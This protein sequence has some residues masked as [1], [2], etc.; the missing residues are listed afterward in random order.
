MAEASKEFYPAL[1]NYSVANTERIQGPSPATGYRIPASRGNVDDTARYI[2]RP[3]AEFYRP[4]LANPPNGSAFVWPVGVE[5]FQYSSQATTGIHHYIGDNDVD[6]DVV[7]PDELHITLSGHF[8][9]KTSA[10]FMQALRKV[11]LDPA[12]DAGKILSLP[13]VEDQVLYVK[14]VNH[15][16]VHDQTDNT[17]SIAYTIEMIKVGAGKTLSLPN[18]VSPAPNPSTKTKARGKSSKQTTVKQ[19]ARTVRQVSKKV[20][21]SASAASMY[22]LI[23]ANAD[24][25][26]ADGIP[27]YTVPFTPL[28]GGRTLKY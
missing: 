16:F 5:G 4:W 24:E 25:L 2:L 17:N 20:Y 1:Q 7:Y 13:G 9:G 14:V 15:S 6:V 19:G 3:D 18:L 12:G 26:E 22:A 27:A 11:I 28:G 10:S 21:G 23:Q 8:P